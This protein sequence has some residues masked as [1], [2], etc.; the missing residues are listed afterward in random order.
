MPI[1]ITKTILVNRFKKIHDNKYDYSHVDYINSK[2]KVQIICKQHGMFEQAPHKH[3]IGQMCPQCSLIKRSNKRKKN[4]D[5]VINDFKNIHGDKYDYSKIDYINTHSKVIIICKIHGD[6]KQSP[7]GHRSGQECPKC[8]G[9]VSINQDEVIGNFKN[10]HGNKYNYSKV[11]YIN[12]HFKVII[13]CK[14]HGEFKQSPS[15]HK[16]GS[17]CPKC[18]GNIK[19]NNTEVINE[20]K[21]IYGNKYDYSQ[22]NYIS[23]HSKVKIICKKHGVFEQS[24]AMH[25]SGRNCPKCSGRGMS[26]SEWIKD[27]KIVHGNIYDYS[28][29]NYKGSEIKIK[30]VCNKHGV[31]NQKP[32][33]HKNGGGCPKCALDVNRY[34]LENVIKKF[35]EKHGNKY[36]YSK[37][38]YNNN[39]TNIKIIC[40]EHGVF[41]QIP[42]VHMYQSGCPACAPHGFN[43]AKKGYFYIHLIYHQSGKKIA[44]KFGITNRY[45]KRIYFIKKKLS[46]YKLKN[47]FYFEGNGKD[48][49]EIEQMIRN[50]FK[51]SYLNPEIMQDGYTETTKYSDKTLVEIYNLCNKKLKFKSGKKLYMKRLVNIFN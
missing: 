33:Q 10:V 35:K 3:L 37:V 12:T 31:F 6:F 2:S 39:N 14:I 44:L 28:L 9:G 16:Q 20:F 1:K 41:E 21:N 36:D 27:F 25:K 29:V 45:G 7:S 42:S 19:K 48:V 13:I 49:L 15:T 4:I 5:E 46:L 51:T 38:N 26:S 30:I 8:K 34:T 24:P 22:V 18:Y 11:D 43:T 50:K 47:I 32:I 40:K 23:T 17:G